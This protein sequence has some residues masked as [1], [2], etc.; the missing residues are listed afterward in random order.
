MDFSQVPPEDLTP[1][2]PAPQKDSPPPERPRGRHLEEFT[3]GEFLTQLTQ[4]PV[5]TWRAFIQTLHDPQAERPVFSV[6]KPAAVEGIASEVRH[7]QRSEIFQQAD[8]RALGIT[9]VLGMLIAF[10]TLST[11]VLST[12]ATRIDPNGWQSFL[13]MAILFVL[14]S[15]FLGFFLMPSNR[16]ARLQTGNIFGIALPG[17]LPVLAS[18]IILTALTYYT[19]DIN[20]FSSLGFVFWLASVFT[21]CLFFWENTITLSPIKAI[22][23][24]FA[25]ATRDL[26]IR[27]RWRPHYWTYVSLGIILFAG[28]IFF[29]RDS[30]IYLPDMTSD[31][32][33]KLRN[34]IDVLN[35][36]TG[37]F[38]ENNGGRESLQMYLLA[39]LHLITG[40]PI[41]F[42]LLKLATGL[43][44]M[45][46]I[47]AGWWMGRALFGETDK[48][49]ANLVGLIMAAMIATSYW[50][51]M[52]SRLGL[53]IVLTTLI[54]TAL[55]IFL[56][57][58]MRHN[59]RA[60][61]IFAGLVLGFGL[62]TYQAVRM[63]PL[64]VIAGFFIAIIARA[65]NGK[66]VARYMVNFAVLVIVAGAAF[67]PLGRYAFSEQGQAAF[68]QR[69]A[70]RILGGTVDIRD[71]SG[72]VVG[73]RG[74]SVEEI[75]QRIGELWEP[76]SENIRRAILMF[77][78][79]GD[80]AWITGEV[81]GSAEL[82]PL[83]GALFLMG[84]GFL[85]V[86]GIKRRDPAEIL[87]PFALLIM[88]LATALSIGF[89]VEVPSATRA[90]G[91]L[92]IAYLCAAFMLA[93]IATTAL[94]ILPLKRFKY[95]V[96]GVIALLLGF[97]A[98]AN[99]YTYFGKAMPGYRISTFP[100]RQAGTLLAGFSN[101]LGSRGNA[102][103]IGYPNWWDYRAVGI[104]SGDFYW[105][106]GIIEG[107]DMITRIK[108]F[109]QMGRGTPY[110][111]DPTRFMLFFLHPAATDSL[112][113]LEA[114]FP[115]GY[116]TRNTAFNET[117]DFLTYIVPPIGCERA[118]E[119]TVYIP[120]TCEQQPSQ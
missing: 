55:Y 6:A 50:M 12:E 97:S 21:W 102:F 37:I 33:E 9:L 100:Y 110:E 60:D 56:S 24:R 77:N 109:M 54:M 15:T 43:E 31:H 105:S 90:S 27:I 82:D 10:T 23:N 92:P 18:A 29:L 28:W 52:L 67:L 34:T 26:T 114:A 38:F 118:I 64:V 46:M 106:N 71:S 94:N 81:T 7:G 95:V 88:L 101:S 14:I 42:E 62:Y 108:T 73:Q 116:V 32:V 11:T 65:R 53:R 5:F 113:Q 63:M 44:A 58:A 66:T 25:N 78:F 39:A 22:R 8:P 40:I 36:T 41:S 96:Y 87:L 2:E 47:L 91:A 84:I 69:T 80:R 45:L 107:P 3:L 119:L 93:H 17:R 115:G 1:A 51:T 20:K 75:F 103:M 89:V 4:R 120:A 30:S 74:A 72:A 61:F 57:R 68:W 111:P 83:T 19:N 98:V 35:G 48:R 59:R 16:L 76:L 104:E 86:S 49:F 85:T 70:G 117:R 112:Q 79:S 99:H 13:P